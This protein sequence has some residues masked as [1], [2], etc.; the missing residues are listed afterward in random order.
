MSKVKIAVVGRTNNKLS[1]LENALREVMGSGNEAQEMINDMDSI[2]NDR[3]RHSA[4]F[5]GNPSVPKRK[6]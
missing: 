4:Y 5:K 6:R 3:S 1:F 2:D